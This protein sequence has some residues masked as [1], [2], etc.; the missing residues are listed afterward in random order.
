[1]PSRPDVVVT[2]D[3]A[4]NLAQVVATGFLPEDSVPV[5]SDLVLRVAQHICP[6]VRVDMCAVDDLS[7]SAVTAL[8]ALDAPLQ[9]L[10]VA[11]EVVTQPP[12][13]HTGHHLASGWTATGQPPGAHQHQHPSGG[14]DLAA[15]GAARS[16]RP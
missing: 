2:V 15:R 11:L 7:P 9:Q 8:E 16:L 12:R 13:A 10:G 3:P 6:R 1:M 14:A 4:G 5:L